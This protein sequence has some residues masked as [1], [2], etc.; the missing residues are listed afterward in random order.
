MYPRPQRFGFT[1]IELLVVISIIALLIGLLLPSLAAA[2]ETARTIQCSSKMKQLALAAEIYAG[3]HDGAYPNRGVGAGNPG[4][5]LPRWPALFQRTYQVEEILVC[6]NDSEPLSVDDPVNIPNEFDRAPR[7]YMFNGFNDL[8]N[9]FL[10][11]ANPSAGTT[12]VD[13]ADNTTMDQDFV[14]NFGNVILFGEK[15]TGQRG[16]YVDI[17]AGTPDTLVAIE[18]SR[19]GG[20]G[21][22]GRIDPVTGSRRGGISNYAFGDTS[23]R[24]FGFN[25]TIVPENLW[26]VTAAVR[27]P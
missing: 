11:P 12:F 17:F 9:T 22:P 13:G 8:R 14:P 27:N 4:S 23:V 5:G 19:H 16:Y 24:S 15:V 26:A 18:Q 1:L 3:E 2:R 20:T 25:E 6:P 10:N 7:S 21:N